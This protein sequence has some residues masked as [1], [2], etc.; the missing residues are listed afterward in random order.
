M[1]YSMGQYKVSVVYHLP[2]VPY[3][4]KLLTVPFFSSA[5]RNAILLVYAIRIYRA[6][7]SS[8][9]IFLACLSA[10]LSSVSALLVVCSDSVCRLFLFLIASLFA[11]LYLVCRRYCFCSSSH[12]FHFSL[13]IVSALIVVSPSMVSALLVN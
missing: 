7:S 11:S 1:K 3:F 4:L 8:T 6:E 2:T 13:S 9:W 10:S 12:P 5:G